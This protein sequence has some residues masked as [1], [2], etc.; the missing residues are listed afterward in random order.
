MMMITRKSRIAFQEVTSTEPFK[1]MAVI[2]AD[3]TIEGIK[4]NKKKAHDA[5]IIKFIIN[6]HKNTATFHDEIKLYINP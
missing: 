6:L 4:L 5:E 3:K 2:V 1:L